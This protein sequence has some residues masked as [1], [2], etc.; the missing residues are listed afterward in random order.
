MLI[1]RKIGMKDKRCEFS[2][3]ACT[4]FFLARIRKFCTQNYKQS[5]SKDKEVLGDATPLPPNSFLLFDQLQGN[6]S[7]GIACR[8]KKKKKLPPS[9]TGGR[10]L[11]KEQQQAFT[12][13][14][15]E[16]IEALLD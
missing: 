5:D 12:T 7:L 8:E 10:G 3:C 1:L 11:I 4:E 9:L 6:G 2:A 15:T 14:L 16:F 13:L